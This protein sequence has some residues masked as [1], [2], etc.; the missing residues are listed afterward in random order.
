MPLYW[1]QWRLQDT[2][3]G[4]RLSGFLPSKSNAELEEIAPLVE[5]RDRPRVPDRFL[6]PSQ[7]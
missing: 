3:R 1:S 6:L 2:R 4:S 5:Q 7:A